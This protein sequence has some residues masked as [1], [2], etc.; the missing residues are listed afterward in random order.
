MAKDARATAIRFDGFADRNGRF[1]RALARNQRHE[2]F[3]MHRAEYG[4]SSQR[5]SVA[6]T[7]WR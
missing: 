6:A 4:R 2:W 1:F 7:C 5:S 3:A